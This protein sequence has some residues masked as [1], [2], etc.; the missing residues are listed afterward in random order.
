[1]LVPGSTSTDS[2]TAGQVTAE[3]L[4]GAQSRITRTNNSN[5]TSTSTS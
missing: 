5:S 2:G 3:P 1:M 4:A